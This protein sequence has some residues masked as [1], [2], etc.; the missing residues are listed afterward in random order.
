[1]TGRYIA[2]LFGKG[3]RKEYTSQVHGT[4]EAAAAEL[5]AA[6]PTAKHCSTCIARE[7]EPGRWVQT[8]CNI[9]FHDR[10]RAA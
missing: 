2:H 5:F 10:N 9:Y 8:H 6:R 4:R 3:T 7:A 1:M